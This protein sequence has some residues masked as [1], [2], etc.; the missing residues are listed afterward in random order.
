[1]LAAC[2]TTVGFVHRLGKSC[3]S[4]KPFKFNA[5]SVV[6]TFNASLSALAPSALV[7]FAVLYDFGD[8][9]SIFAL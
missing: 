6:L 9:V 5:V 2:G 1:M 4:Y 3:C 7:I 8:A